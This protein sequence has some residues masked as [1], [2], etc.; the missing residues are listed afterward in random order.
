MYGPFVLYVS[1]ELSP[2]QAVAWLGGIWFAGVLIGCLASANDGK[3]AWHDQLAGTAVFRRREIYGLDA[4]PGSG[5]E[6]LPPS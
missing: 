2:N 3:Q 6:P 5:P 4:R 1:N